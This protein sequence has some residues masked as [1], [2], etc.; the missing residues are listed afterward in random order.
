MKKSKLKDT[1]QNIL[2]YADIKLDGDR[3]YDIQVH[4]DK[5]YQ[6][7]LAQGSLGLGE[8]Y[9]DHWWDCEKLDE[10]FYRVTKADLKDKVPRN[11]LLKDVLKAK[12]L[13]LQN[14]KRAFEIGERHYDIGNNLYIH[15]LDKRLNYTCGYWKNVDNLDDAQESKLALICKKIH[16]KAGMEVLDLG[17]G[18]G[19]FAKYAA[20]SYGVKVTGVTVSKEQVKLG[21]EL[22]RGLPVEIRY[23]DYRDIKEKYDTIVSIGIIEHVGYKNYRI[24]MNKVDE[25]LKDGGLFLLHT[26]GRNDSVTSQEPWINKYIF[27]NAITPTAAQITS[28]CEDIFVIEDWHNFGAD[29]DKTLMAWYSNFENNWDEIKDD[30]DERFRRMWTYYLLSCAGGFRSRKSQL[31]Q[32]VFS[33][34]GVP[35]GYQSIR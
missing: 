35:G 25:C 33:K 3:P 16:L 6:R 2:S 29:Y 23:Q 17:C 5:L 27:P 7:V 34:K 20:E 9:M 8:S 21:N 4:N 28:A 32:I 12:L 14:K 13:N 24:F 26:I 31:W 30:Y 18:W 19:N 22:C 10:F 1:F 15:M 11:S